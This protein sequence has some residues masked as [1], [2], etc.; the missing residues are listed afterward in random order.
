MLYFRP[1]TL[2]SVLLLLDA[3]CIATTRP[4]PRLSLFN[5]TNPLLCLVVP[6]QFKTEPPASPPGPPLDTSDYLRLGK[7][8]YGH[9]L[10]P[11][12]NV[13]EEDK[14]TQEEWD[15]R[16]QNILSHKW[17]NWKPAGLRQ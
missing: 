3:E 17:K 16:K 9:L 15:R 14:E 4:W 6:T 7:M 2:G 12:A 5:V 11:L 8:L 10:R 1:V 13:A